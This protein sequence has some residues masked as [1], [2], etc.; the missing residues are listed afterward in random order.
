MGE[1]L[2][3]QNVGAEAEAAP[4]AGQVEATS[5]EATTETTEGQAP[6]VQAQI[7]A[8]VQ[9]VIDKYERKG[10]GHL[11]KLR[12]TKDKEIAALK[13]QLR[14]RQNSQI[15]EAKELMD[16][17]PAQAAQLLASIVEAQTQA[18]LQDTKH[19]ELVDWQHKILT[20]LGADPEEDEEAAELA[21]EWAEKLIEDPNLTWDFQQEAARLQLQRKEQAIKETTK[22]L[23]E[24]KEG[25][26][27]LIKAEVTKALAG[28]G[29]I[30]EPS[31]DGEPPQ[32]EENWRDQ[33]SSQL[34]KQGLTE[35]LKTPIQR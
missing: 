11:A 22:E 14:E 19:Q 15:A 21:A 5:S 31:D 4:E 30:P 23:T 34:I 7:D 35:R 12:S 20:D 28:A 17:D 10:D 8:A 27:D 6:D 32:R 33:P 16:S 3:E 29:I 1:E 24:L 25:M 13:R 18:S 9:A 26:P 2:N